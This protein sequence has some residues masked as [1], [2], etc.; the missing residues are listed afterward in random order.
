MLTSTCG[1]KPALLTQCKRGYSLGRVIRKLILSPVIDLQLLLVFPSCSIIMSISLSLKKWHWKTFPIHKCQAGK[2]EAQLQPIMCPGWPSQLS[3]LWMTGVG[4]ELT[5]P[6]PLT[7]WAWLAYLNWVWCHNCSV[8][9]NSVVRTCGGLIGYH[10]SSLPFPQ[11]HPTRKNKHA[12]ILGCHSI[13]LWLGPLAAWS[14][15]PTL[16]WA[17]LTPGNWFSLPSDYNKN[18]Q[19]WVDS[20]LIV[21]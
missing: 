7:W 6:S 4:W 13:Y 15:F 18:Y 9:W 2:Y 14:Y 10:S 19:I 8:P 5:P 16:I 17:S 12:L 1:S 3:P 20:S 11:L 21:A